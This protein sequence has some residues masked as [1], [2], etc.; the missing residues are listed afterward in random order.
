MEEAETSM[1]STTVRN[2]QYLAIAPHL[3]E[4][5]LT[6]LGALVDHGPCTTRALAIRAGIDLLT[7]RPRVTELLEMGLATIAG[8]APEGGLYRALTIAEI[9]AKQT[10]EGRSTETQTELF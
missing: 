10:R 5:Q 3:R 9:E 8:R 7:V 1:T 2:E 6:V 4:L